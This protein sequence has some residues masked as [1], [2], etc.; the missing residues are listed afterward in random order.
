M[1]FLSILF[2]KKHI[3]S[4][5]KINYNNKEISIENKKIKTIALSILVGLVTVGIGGIIFFY[6]MT[7]KYKVDAIKKQKIDTSPNSSLK[8]GVKPQ[9]I[10]NTS[11]KKFIDD[12]VDIFLHPYITGEI[13]KETDSKDRKPMMEL[14]LEKM[15]VNDPS[16]IEEIEILALTAFFKKSAL[17]LYINQKKKNDEFDFTS[18]SPEFEFLVNAL[19]DA[20]PREFP[21][22]K[23][24]SENIR[25]NASLALFIINKKRIEEREIKKKEEETRLKQEE[26][27]VDFRCTKLEKLQRSGKLFLS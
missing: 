22:K 11:E 6:S 15:N 5:F 27:K 17:G 21:N 16:K 18:E 26:E 4:P 25:K 1:N 2:S 13:N 23:I 12:F 10:I 8:P 7:A 3:Q 20:L 24:P 19:K 14:L 9:E